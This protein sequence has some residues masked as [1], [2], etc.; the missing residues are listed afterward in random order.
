MTGSSPNHICAHDFPI[1]L[2]ASQC[3]EFRGLCDG[4]SSGGG[5]CI[6]CEPQGRAA[7]TMSRVV[8]RGA[9]VKSMSSFG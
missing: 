2:K 9:E 1:M 7:L 8:C 5:V 4:V 3:F 6:C